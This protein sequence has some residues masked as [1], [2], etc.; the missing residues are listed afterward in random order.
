M[1]KVNFRTMRNITLQL[2][3][4]ITG[5]CFFTLTS[6]GQANAK[7][8]VSPP[9]AVCNSIIVQLDATG[10]HTLTTADIN[11]IGSGS[12]DP[13]GGAVTLSVTPMF[14]D[15]TKVGDNTI[16]LTVT[17][18]DGYHANCTTIL[19]V[20]DGT[21]PQGVLCQPYT[22]FLG[23][24]GTVT[25]YPADVNTATPTDNCGIASYMISKSATGPFTPFISYNC[26]DIQTAGMP[27]YISVIDVHGNGA[28]CSSLI[29]IRDNTAPVVTCINDVTLYTDSLH[30]GANVTLPQ[31]T[32]VENCGSATIVN[33][34]NQT[35]NASG[36][37]NV[38]TT[39][40]VWTITDQYGNAAT[41]TMKVIVIDKIAPVITC[42]AD[43]L[44]C[45]TETLVLGNATATDICGITSITN[46]AP[47]TFSPGVTNVVWTATDAN[48]NVS[49]KTQKVTIVPVAIVNAGVDASI[50]ES[51]TF[52][53]NSATSKDAP[54][55]LWT[56]DGKG[57]L[58]G[59]NTLTPT[60]TPSNGET[61]LVTLTLTAFQTSPCA[62]DAKDKL[63]L[64]INPRVIA[65]ANI[66]QTILKGNAT[67]L[68]GTATGGTGPYSWNWQPA[69]L[70][71]NN[72]IANPTTIV[73]NE[74]AQFTVTVQNIASG[75]TAIDS[76]KVFVVTNQP[77]IAVDDHRTIVINTPAEIDLTANDSDPDG[78][79]IS[80]T[81]LSEPSHGTVT[82]IDNNKV[83]YTP[84]PNYI[85]TDEFT[86]IICDDGSP[87]MCDTAQAFITISTVR[88]MLEIFNLITPNDD[89]K[90]DRWIIN[91]IEEFP[92][93]E[94]LIFNR[95]GDKIRQFNNYDNNDVCWNGTNDNNEFVPDG[96]YYYIIKIKDLDSFTGWV[97]V[98]SKGNKK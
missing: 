37:Y 28:Y 47:A 26:S 3:C 31:P 9:V 35:S 68:N 85:G 89:G 5:I 51:S 48:G 59:A 2:I 18:V 14:F 19:T 46:N 92:D 75:C 67:Q 44:I 1:L 15:C 30:C 61:G 24:N 80:I 93:N 84:A 27:F 97:Y 82:S 32:F 73:L 23:A 16:T 25:V 33:N 96:T 66:D 87:S 72:K 95:W 76:M 11:A 38:G 54:S 36:F 63:N 34:F 88:D 55:I 43:I 78:D 71:V 94:I 8:G 77:P 69:E 29:K 91:G 83:N 13:D 6:S 70:L 41:C 90:N 4:L 65:N 60:Y 81:F 56:H 22:A 10:Q 50:C 39:P 21:P 12:Y 7:M 79:Q 45:S 20:T 52:T 57:T 62:P 17:D 74:N 40:V 58:S 98:N 49:T 42:P 86:Y 64:Q 53:V